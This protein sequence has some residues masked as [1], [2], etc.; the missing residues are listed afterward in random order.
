MLGAHN[1]NNALAALAAARHAG[2]Q[3]AVACEALAQYRNVKRRLEHRATVNDISVYDDF[4]H[5]P[6]AIR[7]TLE[8][9]RR[10]VGADRIIA[11]LEPRSNTMRM[12]VHKDSLAESLEPADMVCIFEPP[13]LGWSLTNSVHSL[14]DRARVYLSIEDIVAQVAQ[15]ARPSDHI[16]I[17]SNGAFGGIHRKLIEALEQHHG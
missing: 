7:H 4:A 11:I 15:N 10:K 14:G 9:L 13:D 17:M 8:G 3:A 16:L 2:V 5:H 1:V 12:G 6:T